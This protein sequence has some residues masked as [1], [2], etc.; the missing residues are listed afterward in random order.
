[1]G[2]QQANASPSN[3]SPS[4][5]PH[6]KF[7]TSGTNDRLAQQKSNAL[8]TQKTSTSELL[9][10]ITETGRQIGEKR[11]QEIQLYIP[12]NVKIVDEKQGWRPG[13]S[14]GANPHFS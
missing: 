12:S 5:A 7:L 14:V 13:I 6:D 3:A 2:N 10:L 9:A 4:S 1:M 11:G 8:E